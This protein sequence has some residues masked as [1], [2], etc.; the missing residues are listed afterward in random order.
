MIISNDAIFS[1]KGGVWASR[2][3]QRANNTFCLSARWNGPVPGASEWNRDWVV[4][5]CYQVGRESGL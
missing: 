5:R 1:D 4:T 2:S 3:F